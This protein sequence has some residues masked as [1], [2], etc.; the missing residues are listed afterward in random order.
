MKEELLVGAHT[1][2]SGGA[3]KALLQ[4]REIG[5]STIQL[6]TSNQKTWEGKIISPEEVKLWEEAKKSTHIHVTMSHDSYLINL[7]SPNPDVWEKSKVAFGKEIE[8]CHLLEIDYLN[9]HPGAFTTSSRE[10]C[11]D[12]IA[13]TLLTFEKSVTKGKTRLLIETTAGQGSCVGSSFEEIAYLVDRTKDKIPIGVC[14]DTCHIFAAG[15]DIRT[16]ESWT[17]TLQQFDQ[18]VGL[19]HLYAFHL[20]DSMQ[21]LGSRKDRH[22]SLGDGEIGLACFEF[23]MTHPKLKPLPKYLETPYSEKWPDEIQMLK[24][25]AKGDYHAS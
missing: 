24:K 10:E 21:P 12:L 11:L 19:D 9:F 4:G 8:R 23:I 7:G 6:F 25:M 18:I 15:Y 2:A 5:A 22:A 3:Y 1:S 13:K 20:N 14:I 16:K 17:K